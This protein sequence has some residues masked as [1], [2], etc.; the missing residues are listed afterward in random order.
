MTDAREIT[1][2]KLLT[3]ADDPGEHLSA[4]RLRQLIGSPASLDQAPAPVRKAAWLAIG[5]QMEGHC[6]KAL[7]L[8]IL[9]ALAGA[10][11]SYRELLEDTDPARHPRGNVV[12]RTFDAWTGSASIEPKIVVSF[13]GGVLAT[14]VL[15][16]TADLTL[17][18]VTFSIEDRRI[19]A[20]HAAKLLATARLAV[21]D[22]KLWVS[23]EYVIGDGVEW[24]LE[25]GIA[26]AP[27]PGNLVPARAD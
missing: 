1:F 10:T 24:N 3:H 11:L 7:D 19:R 12:T 4:K 8:P 9:E 22:H 23:R 21:Q 26:I 5:S 6:A 2:W 15:S 14:F 20:I 25:P 27:Q 17:E 13:Q 18:G 16:A